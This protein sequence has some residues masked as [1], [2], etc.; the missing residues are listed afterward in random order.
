MVKCRTNGIGHLHLNAV[1]NVITCLLKSMVLRV[2]QIVL[3]GLSSIQFNQHAMVWELFC[4]QYM[5]A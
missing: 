2:A 4:N 1:L 5:S 3:T